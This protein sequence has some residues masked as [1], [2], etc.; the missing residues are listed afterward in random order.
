MTDWKLVS[1]AMAQNERT[2]PMWNKLILRVV[3]AFLGSIDWV[4][5]ARRILERMSGEVN[6][7]LGVSVDLN[8]LDLNRLFGIIEEVLNDYCKLSIDLNKDGVIG[9]GKE[10]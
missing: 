8:R 4:A 6:E 1:C 9:D 10:G 3:L 7:Q 5:I 2:K